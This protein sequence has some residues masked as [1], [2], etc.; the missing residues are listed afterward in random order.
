MPEQELLPQQ[1]DSLA[2][3]HSAESLFSSATWTFYALCLLLKSRLKESI[4]LEVYIDLDLLLL[5]FDT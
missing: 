4:I 1:R 2:N 3:K 5:H